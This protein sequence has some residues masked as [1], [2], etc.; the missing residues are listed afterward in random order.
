MS[1]VDPG[2]DPETVIERQTKIIDALMR[3]AGRQKQVSGSAYHAFQSAIELQQQVT[4]QSL[5]LETVRQET[6]RTR[7]SLTQ[8]LSAMEEGL[9]LFFENRLDVFNDLFRN[10][11]PDITEE[12][13]VGLSLPEYLMRMS[14]SA[15]VV[16]TDID[17]QRTPELLLPG[18]RKNIAVSVVAELTGDR[19]YQLS[20]RVTSPQNTVLLLTEITSLIRRNRMEKETLIDRQADYLDAVF[21]NMQSGL[22]TFSADDQLMMHN[23]RFREIL[24]LPLT[25]V[26]KG[27]NLQTLLKAMQAR[28][29]ISTRDLLSLEGWR[30]DLQRSGM[31]QRRLTH[32]PE[33]VI[34]VHANMLPDGG[35]LVEVKDVTLETR[36]TAMLENRV[37]E[38]TAELTHANANLTLQYKQLTRAEEELRIA[39]ERAEAAVSSKTRFLAAA[40]HDLLQPINAAKLLISTLQ[41]TTRDTHFLPMVNRLERAFHSAEQLLQSL[42]DLSRL[43]ST[44]PDSVDPV[45]VQLGALISGVRDDQELVAAQKDVRLEMVPCSLTVMSDPVYLLRS[46]QNLVVNAIQ[47]TQPG[48]RV[49]VGCRRR[50]GKVVLQV[51][52]TGVGI[53]RDDQSRIFDEFTRAENGLMEPGVGLGLSVVDRACRLLGHDLA[54]RSAPGRGSMFSIEMDAVAGKGAEV[55]VPKAMKP[56]RDFPLSCIVMVIEN[57]PDVLYGSVQ[58]LESWGASVLAAARI[59]EALVM[60]DDLGMAP[61]IILADFQLDDGETGVDAIEQIRAVTQVNVPAI[62]ITADRSVA[63]RRIGLPKDVSVLS[64]PVKLTRLRPLIDWKIRWHLQSQGTLPDPV[65]TKVGNDSPALGRKD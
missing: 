12:V 48:G 42:L 52:D 27:V 43:E 13:K 38:R 39:K 23:G 59:S 18:L 7:Q 31:L 65:Q 34:D 64:K 5:E 35:Y 14:R 56:D 54:V 50:G 58:L 36:S 10:L 41:Q 55:K 3:R 61:D 28:S 1:I 33:R 49:M 30:S 9:A 57:D 8:A 47:Y 26:Q 15:Y 19:W 6:E 60:L 44:D 17:L 16:S 63:M 45:P 32:G 24:A 37:M 2:A 46:I 25:E 11:L 40:S 29:L 4:A 53:S 21:Q 51:W 22:G 20:A 62:I